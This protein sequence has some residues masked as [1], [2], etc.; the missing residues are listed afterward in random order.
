[1]KQIKTKCTLFMEDY[2]VIIVFTLLIILVL[3]FFINSNKLDWNTA[4]STFIS[5]ALGGLLVITVEIDQRIRGDKKSELEKLKEKENLERQKVIVYFTYLRNMLETYSGCLASYSTI[6][7]G[8]RLDNNIAMLRVSYEYRGLDF[9]GE[10]SINFYKNIMQLETNIA[11]TI[12]KLNNFNDGQKGHDAYRRQG[13]RL[14]MVVCAQ[15]YGQIK[16]TNNYCKRYYGK[17]L[18]D[19]D[20]FEIV[21]KFKT[22]TIEQAKAFASR[23]QDENNDNKMLNNINN[24]H[25]EW[26]LDF[27]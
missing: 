10:Y 5:T 18:L 19:K 1:M 14:F 13:E 17:E 21:E 6:P 26:V 8:Y 15:L 7:N 24:S 11:R 12:E 2:G 27:K 16:S 23:I 3:V 9:I 22:N 20:S 25:K 4:W